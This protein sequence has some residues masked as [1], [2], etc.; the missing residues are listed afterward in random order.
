MR[1]PSETLVRVVA[2]PL[3]PHCTK[4]HA[5]AEREFAR[6]LGG[7]ILK[8]LRMAETNPLSQV[9]SGDLNAWGMSVMNGRG[10]H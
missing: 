1:L 10:G 8:V 9:V 2:V 7:L 3:Y 6:A 4:Q 5:Q